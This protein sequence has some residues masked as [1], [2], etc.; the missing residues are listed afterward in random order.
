MKNGT[1]RAGGSRFLYEPFDVASAKIDAHQMVFEERWKALERRLEV[2]ETM[3]ERLER[4]L[5]L[6]VYGVAAAVILQGAYT[7]MNNQ[8]I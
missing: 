8:F 4:R 3:L 7:L 2:I 6:A 5:W 1:Q